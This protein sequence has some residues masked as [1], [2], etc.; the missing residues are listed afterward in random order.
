MKNKKKKGFTLIELVI[1]IAI[2]GILAAVALPKYNNSRLAAAE[3]AH[4]S[5]VQMLKS[6]ALVKQNEMSSSDPDITWN[7]VESSKGYVEKWPKVPAGLKSTNNKDV[8]ETYIVTISSTN[9]E[10]SP[11]EEDLTK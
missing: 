2:I 3:A 9:I 1:V 5:N 7:S 8:P 11:S 10:I 6:A 4:K